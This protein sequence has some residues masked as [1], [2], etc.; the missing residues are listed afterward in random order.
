MTF[1]RNTHGK[2]K[3]SM[4]ACGYT[5]LLPMF[6]EIFAFQQLDGVFVHLA[7]SHGKG[8]QVIFIG[9][10]SGTAEAKCLGAVT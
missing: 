2:T 4:G 5:S 10:F 7:V 8:N 1:H 3:F 6:L 9:N